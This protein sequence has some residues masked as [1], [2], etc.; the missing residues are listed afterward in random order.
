[1]AAPAPVPGAP[2]QPLAP[3][4]G[5]APNPPPPPPPPK[6]AKPRPP[7]PKVAAIPRPK[8]SPGLAGRLALP[9]N[10]AAPPSANDVNAAMSYTDSAKRARETIATD[11]DTSG[12][13]EY[14]HALTRQ[15]LDYGP[16]VPIPPGAVQGAGFDAATR[17]ILAQIAGLRA[18]MSNMATAD[19]IRDVRSDISQLQA[20]VRNTELRTRNTHA[21]GVLGA[22]LSPLVKLFQGFGP[23]APGAWAPAPLGSAPPAEIPFPRTKQQL[24]ALS[25][26][27]VDS[28]VAW[29]NDPDLTLS[30]APGAGLG[31]RLS[32]VRDWLA[33]P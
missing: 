12:T 24:F 2:P 9:Q 3:G 28:I 21:L 7:A 13:T 33:R 26:T 20:Q 19:M 5:A 31:S 18:E 32:A 17:A 25:N 27:K 6:G 14:E 30:A 11:A 16:E 8:Q 29:Y 10:P 23:G 15:K 22:A 1:M 4:A